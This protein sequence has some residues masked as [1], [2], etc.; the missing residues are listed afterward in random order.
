MY[1]YS[2]ADRCILSHNGIYGSRGRGGVDMAVFPRFDYLEI[3]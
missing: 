1:E 3:P 2:S